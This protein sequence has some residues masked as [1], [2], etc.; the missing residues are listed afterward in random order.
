MLLHF[1]A[2][3]DRVLEWRLQL[4]KTLV[5]KS[6]SYFHFLYILIPLAFLVQRT[7]HSIKK[8]NSQVSLSHSPLSLS[9]LSLSG[10]HIH[11]H[12]S[13]SVFSFFSLQLFLSFSSPFSFPIFFLLCVCPK[14]VYLSSIAKVVFHQLLLAHLHQTTLE[15]QVPEYNLLEI[16]GIEPMTSCSWPDSSNHWATKKIPCVALSPSLSFCPSLGPPFYFFLPFSL[17][18]STSRFQN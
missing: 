5:K 16:T 1:L 14:T 9:A 8:N 6:C 13:F 15:N 2:K 12:L 7:P 3:S 4:R 18:L 17:S 10:L 11:K